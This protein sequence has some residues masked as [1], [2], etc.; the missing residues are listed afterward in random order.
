M[1]DGTE[2]DPFEFLPVFAGEISPSNP[3]DVYNA[4]GKCF[5]SIS[6]QLQMTSDTTFDL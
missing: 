1:P 6:F 3:T 4:V 2:A 5:E